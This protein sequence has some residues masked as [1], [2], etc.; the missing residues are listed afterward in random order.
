MKAETIQKIK[1]EGLLAVLRGPSEDLTVRMVEAL[2]AGGVL[3]IEI[4]F[5]TPNAL[6]VIETLAKRYGDEII[7]GVGTVTQPAQALD[8]KN[9]GAMFLVSPHTEE[10]LVKSM[11][12]T[13]L[14]LMSGAL[15][16]SE[17]VAA[18]ALGADIVKIF[19]GSLVGPSYIK[20]LRGPYPDLQAVPTGG[21][22]KNNIKDWFEA[23]AVAVGAGSN[24][25]PK[26]WALEGKFSQIT[27]NAKE[28]K[29]IVNK[30]R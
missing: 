3:G 11:V 5:T 14:P 19:P 23:G 10:A 22:N 25:C 18:Q 6:S 24:L 12:E 16:P 9:A 20:A 17:I 1:T 21:V 2:I 8:S 7:L 27:A 28:Y 4:T 13:G 26:Q 29:E 15:T 30:A